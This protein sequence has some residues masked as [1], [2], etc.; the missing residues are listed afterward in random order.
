MKYR[1]EIDGLRAMAVLPVILFHAGFEA[2]SGGFIGVDVF[3]VISGYLITSIIIAELETGTFSLAG[4]YERRARRILPALFF[5][6][7]ACLPFAWLWLV[8]SELKS[9]AQSVAAV[10]AFASNFLFWQETGYFDTAAELKPLLHTWSL[11]VEEQFYVLFPLLLMSA[12]HLGKRRIVGLLVAIALASLALADWGASRYPA[13]TFFLL[14]TR[15]WELALGAFTAFWFARPQRPAIDHRIGEIGSGAGLLLI[16]YAVFA[17]D[18][19]TPFPSLHALVPTVGTALVILFATPATLAGR[20]LGARALVG[21]GLVSYSAYLWHQPLFAFARHHA[22]VQPGAGLLLGLSLASLALAYLSWRFVEQPFRRRGFLERRTVFRLA[23]AASVLFIMLG[24]AGMF[25]DGFRNRLP[26]NLEWES[27]REKTRTLGEVCD[28]VPLAGVEGVRAC[29]FGDLESGQVIFL[30]GDSHARAL[31]EALHERL[32]AEGIKGVRVTLPGCHVVPTMSEAGVASR[33]ED[34]AASYAR[35]LE[36]LPANGS[37]IIVTGRWTFSL[38]PI[39]GEIDTLAF[40]NSDGGHEIERYRQF[41]VTSAGGV[42]SLAAADKAEA[43]RQFIGSL[44]ATGLDVHFVYPVPEI[45]WNIAAVNMRHYGQHGRPLP[46]L[47]IAQ[48]D[49]TARNAF[50]HRELARFDAAPNFIPVRPA[51]VF[52]D[53]FIP[54]RCAAQHE[55][56]PFYYDDDHLSDVGARLV[57]DRLF[58]FRDRDSRQRPSAN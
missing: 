45:G 37:E 12:W 11:A 34:C 33:P 13:A 25:A 9:F 30:Y 4:F 55:T 48:E 3:F 54:G 39:A 36:Y 14:H 31:H 49:F 27:L 1:R 26:A 53:T 58:E 41:V 43:L 51:D 19:T 40:T 20:I 16:L 15:A 46:E 22:L 2:F 44:L 32:R 35:L 50:V 21:V 5:V 52:C 6:M 7:A 24:A 47:S 10:A 17:F 56:V 8:P 38:Y 28:P 42:P 57:I 23:G 18:R 29:E